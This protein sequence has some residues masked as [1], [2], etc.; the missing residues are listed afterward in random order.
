MKRIWFAVIFMIAVF[1]LCMIQQYTVS[2]TYHQMDALFEEMTNDA[3]NQ[4]F[5]SIEKTSKE[6]ENI[7]NKRHFILAALNEHSMLSDA[8]ITLKSIDELAKSESDSLV[9]T[10][11]EAR[12]KV[13]AIYHSSRITLENVF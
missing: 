11:T 2:S 7:W 10:I 9:E 5:S 12:K 3:N 1:G 4:N 8:A 6:M 13:E